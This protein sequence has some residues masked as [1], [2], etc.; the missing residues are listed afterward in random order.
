[1]QGKTGHMGIQKPPCSSV[2]R[3]IFRAF[4][5]LQVIHARC[6]SCTDHGASLRRREYCRSDFRVQ[7][8]RASHGV[9]RSNGSRNTEAFLY[10]P[11]ITHYLFLDCVSKWLFLAAHRMCRGEI[12]GKSPNAGLFVFIHLASV[13]PAAAR[14]RAAAAVFVYGPVPGQVAAPGPTGARLVV[15]HLRTPE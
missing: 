14:G 8:V 1:M 15:V 12:H 3:K 5:T 6:S 4:I 7:A 2:E 13:R 9:T 11:G 10:V